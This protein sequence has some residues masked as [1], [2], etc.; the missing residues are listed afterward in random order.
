MS[1]GWKSLP[2]VRHARSRPRFALGTLL[3]LALFA[4]LPH[5]LSAIT[6]ALIGWNSGA[7]LY[8]AL[9]LWIASGAT[10]DTMRRRA[11]LLDEGRFTVL[12]FTSVASL[13]SLAAIV[14]ELSASKTIAEPERWLHVALAGST[15]V[16]SWG[17]MHMVFAQHYAHEYYSVHRAD[18]EKSLDFPGSAMPV[19]WDFYYFSY[20]IGAAA[21]TADV[22]V[23]ST[24]SRKTAVAH[25]VLAFFFNTFILALTINI[26]AS[27]L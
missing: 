23:T 6:R 13:A 16:L 25:G 15:V 1:N 11:I 8:V 19:Y 21:Q 20:V 26:G 14:Y 24:A 2:V 4:A 5:G 27:L 12:T 10:P 22:S 7:A 18:H 17:F 9:G 3:G